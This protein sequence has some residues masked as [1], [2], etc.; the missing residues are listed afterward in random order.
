[1]VAV[2][3]VAAV[4]ATRA[5]WRWMRLEKAK[6]KKAATEWPLRSAGCAESMGATAGIASTTRRKAEVKARTKAKA[7]HKGPLS[8]PR[9]KGKARTIRKARAKAN[10][11]A[12]K[13]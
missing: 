13:E 6:E 10:P 11:E 4:R 5:P 7:K 8:H 2:P 12:R 3:A 9:E 1:M